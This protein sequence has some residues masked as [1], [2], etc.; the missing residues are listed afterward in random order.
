V[1]EEVE[2][3]GSVATEFSGMLDRTALS[4]LD[5]DAQAAKLLGRRGDRRL[6]LRAW[7]DD[8]GRAVR[9]AWAVVT[10]PENAAG[11]TPWTTTEFWDF[12]VEVDLSAPPEE[13]TTS[14]ASL[15]EIVR[16]IRAMR[17]RSDP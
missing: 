10:P 6:A 15:L 4:R 7:L 13:L 1:G 8:V 11:T 3:R 16:D 12:G 5:S 14:P 17:K 9:I 2:V